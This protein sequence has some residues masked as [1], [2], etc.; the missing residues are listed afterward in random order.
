MVAEAAAVPEPTAH[1]YPEPDSDALL[2]S[3]GTP[4]SPAPRPVYRVLPNKVADAVIQADLLPG[5]HHCRW[6][7]SGG[8]VF[9]ERRR[10][11]KENIFL[12]KQL[13]TRCSGRAEFRIHPGNCGR[14]LELKTYHLGSGGTA[15]NSKMKYPESGAKSGKMARPGVISPTL[16]P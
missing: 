3:I 13:W 12:G 2:A 7:G 15:L 10:R 6:T 4:R 11:K 9:K 8:G 1:T 5:R 14:C 16:A